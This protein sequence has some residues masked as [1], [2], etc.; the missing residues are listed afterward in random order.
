MLQSFRSRLVLSN[1]LVTLLGLLV[2]VFVFTQL[3]VN[4]STEV[5]KSDRAAQ[6]QGVASQVEALFARHGGP[7]E[8]QQQIDLASRILGVRV[9]VTTMH[10]SIPLVD[11]RND[12]R[13]YSSVQ[14]PLDPVAFRKGKAAARALFS[15]SNLL[16]FQAPL[17]GH[18]SKKLIGAVVLIA[19][20][21]DV[22]PGF[23]AFFQLLLTVLGSALAVWLIIGLYFSL[24][25][26][27]PLVK[28]TEA[29]SRM[30]HGDYSARVEVPGNSEIAQLAAGFNGMAE[31]VQR[32][33]RLLRDFLANVSH[34]LRTPLTTIAGFSAAVLDGTAEADQLQASAA[35]INEEAL[36]MQHLVDDLMQ[37]TRLESG[38]LKLEAHP[39]PLR[40]FVANLLHR[41]ENSA[42]DR[43]LPALVNSIPEDLP[44]AALDEIQ[45][46]RAL[47]N[48]L[49]NAIQYT[50][51]EGSVRFHAAIADERTIEIT[52]SDTGRGMSAE[53]V[54]RIFERFYRSDKSRDRAEGHAGLGL[55]IVKEV[56]EGHG[57]TIA[58]ESRLGAGTTFR[59][60]VPRAAI[61]AESG[62][63]RTVHDP[64][65]AVSRG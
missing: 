63:P 65:P 46:E 6:A 57:G 9:I 22:Q 62:R 29:T 51:S 14:T 21:Q 40:P 11:S 32:T 49:D 41:A 25:I 50:P 1:L 42:P 45:F 34:D 2:V 28:V 60:R 54:S 4:R 38:L 23:S 52:V 10:S 13:F 27:R 17:R 33:N 30:A 3:L 35:I 31:E 43:P 56:V 8:L 24:S 47:Q 58:V 48:L 15:N 37:L 16:F 61:P 12:T 64:R 39:V 19:R 26:S 7:K 5:K 59:V 53:E 44:P 20:V 18:V 36:K 55:A